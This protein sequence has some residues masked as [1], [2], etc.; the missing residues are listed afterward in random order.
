MNK[1]EVLNKIG[2]IT[3]YAR[4]KVEEINKIMENNFLFNL[5]NKEK[6]VNELSSRLNISQEEASNIYDKVID[7]F[8][9]TIIDKLK[10]PIG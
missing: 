9:K 4:D 6:I 8:N 5:N 7:F 10:N 1:E 2:E 3:G